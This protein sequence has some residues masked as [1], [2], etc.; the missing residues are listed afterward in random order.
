M[1]EYK[2]AIIEDDHPFR[3]VLNYFLGESCAMFADVSEFEDTGFDVVFTDLKLNGTWGVDT[4]IA[5]RKKTTAPIII[6]TGLGG[7]Y[8]S[9]TVMKSLIDA[10]ASEVWTK[11]VIH[12]PAFIEMARTIVRQSIIAKQG[13]IPHEKP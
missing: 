2:V 7:A 9:G 4:V 10:G 11:Q 12:D 13:V 1:R 3:M 6:M 8:L 5:L